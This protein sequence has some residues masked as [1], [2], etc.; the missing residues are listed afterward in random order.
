MLELGTISTDWDCQDLSQ[1]PI[2]S[3]SEFSLLTEGAAGLNAVKEDKMKYSWQRVVL[4]GRP[5]R[6]KT[7][8]N[9][10][11]LEIKTG[12]NMKLK[13]QAKAELSAGL[14]VIKHCYTRKA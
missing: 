1:D 3:T 10:P 2:Q 7:N 11:Q 14:Y 9:I 13:C 5:N 12:G 8:T 6:F 4:R